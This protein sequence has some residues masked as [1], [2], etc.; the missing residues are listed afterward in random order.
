[1]AVKMARKSVVVVARTICKPR[2]EVGLLFL[3][4]NHTEIPH[5][6]SISVSNLDSGV[7]TRE[8]KGQDL[9]KEFGLLNVNWKQQS[10]G[11]H[12]LDDI[13]LLC[14]E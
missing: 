14:G 3:K 5:L 4:S 2:Q 12:F 9:E 13:I 8:K 10:R 6:I 1:M 11:F 7:G